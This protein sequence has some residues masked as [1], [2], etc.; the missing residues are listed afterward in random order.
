MTDGY[1]QTAYILAD[2][3]ATGRSDWSPAQRGNHEGYVSGYFIE[4][5]I[6]H[7]TLTE[8]HDLRLYNGAKKACRLLGGAHRPRQEASGS[9][10][11]K[12]WSR[13]SSDSGGS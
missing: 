10:G 12:R 4:S 11:I 3:K 6:N 1:L 5:A 7:Y 13:R 2:R 8:G 9:T